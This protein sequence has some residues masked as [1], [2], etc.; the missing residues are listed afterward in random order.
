MLD[1]YKD[2]IDD[3]ANAGTYE[4]FELSMSL[5]DQG[6]EETQAMY[7]EILAKPFK[8]DESETVQL[9]G[10]KKE[11]AKDKAELKESW[12]KAMKYEVLSKVVEK[13]EEQ[14]EKGEEG[15]KLSLEELEKEARE[16]VLENYDK[17]YG[18]IA[19]LKRSDRLSTYLNVITS[20]Y[21][22][23]TS[24]FE[25]IDKENFDIRMSGRLEGI[26][27]RLMTKED[28]TEVSNIVVGGPAWKQKELE[29]GDFI[30]KVKQE[31]DKESTDIKGMVINDVVQLIRGDKGTTVTL[32]VKKKD[33]SIKDISIVRDVVITEEGFAKSLILDGKSAGEKIGYIYLPRFY[34]DFNDRNGRFCSTDVAAEV[35]KLTNKFRY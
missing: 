1:T 11:F 20:I 6:V 28:F 18:R 10:E 35:E 5:L 8:F 25:P 34:A 24:Y 7:Q 15:E 4:F 17:W 31:E 22:P 9:D 23:H 29:D 3:E 21:D 13:M 30:L 19:K 14:E 27:A 2:L 26:G 16:S 12:R 32:T 33:G